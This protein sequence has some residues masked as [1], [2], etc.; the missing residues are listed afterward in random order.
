MAHCDEALERI[1]QEIKKYRKAHNNRNPGALM[2]LIECSELNGWDFVCPVGTTPI[3]DCSYV[4]RGVD[5]YKGVPEE[6]IVAY[7]REANHKGRRNVLYAKG[8]VVRPKEE[9]F[10]QQISK[11]NE[12]RKELGLAEKALGK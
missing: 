4:Y 7:D 10:E 3:G 1:W 8:T 11:D 9:V 5:L 12:H 2:D 6:M